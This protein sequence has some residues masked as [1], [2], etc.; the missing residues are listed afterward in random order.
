LAI[1]AQDRIRDRILPH[2]SAPLRQHKYAFN[3]LI[4]HKPGQGLVRP[5]TLE[6]MRRKAYPFGCGGDCW[7]QRQR[8]AFGLRS[9]YRQSKA[10]YETFC[11]KD[12]ATIMSDSDIFE[13]CLENAKD[14]AHICKR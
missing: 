11:F 9:H 12:S 5:E 8:R 4:D 7:F 2:I 10:L 13:A 1:A 3:I 6:R 14:R